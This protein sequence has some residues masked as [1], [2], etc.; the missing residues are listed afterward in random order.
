MSGSPVTQQARIWQRRVR[1]E[2][3]EA[4]RSWQGQQGVAAPHPLGGA[5]G[6]D[7]PGT[8]GGGSSARWM[9]TA[10]AVQ[11]GAEC[12]AGVGDRRAMLPTHAQRLSTLGPAAGS[13]MAGGPGGWA[14]AESRP[15][16]GSSAMSNLSHV[17]SRTGST[18]DT[19]RMNDLEGQLAE[20]QTARRRMEAEI[21]ELRGMLQLC[22]TSAQADPG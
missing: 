11:R 15:G 16:T 20:E 6:A 17:T 12:D 5:D 4:V 13:A 14:A 22:M 21:A 8:P 2:H 19:A 9:A 1:V 3:A 7:G 10:S 18:V